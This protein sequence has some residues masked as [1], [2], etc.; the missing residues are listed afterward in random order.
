[1]RKSTLATVFAALACGCNWPGA[2]IPAESANAMLNGRTAAQYEFPSQDEPKADV[3]VMSY[4]F[5]KVKRREDGKTI[6]AVHV[7]FA[8]VANGDEPYWFDAREQHVQFPN[9]QKVAAVSAKSSAAGVPVIEVP[10]RSS[11]TVDMFFPV[12]PEVSRSSQL[13]RFDVAWRVQVDGQAVEQVTP[14]ERV[15]IDPLVA[16]ERAAIYGAYGWYGGGWGPVAP[17][18]P[19]W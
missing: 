3:R 17:G 19:R 18:Y 8:L 13:P 4:G 5:A 16:Q 6:K 14:F 12:P 15:T 1:M 7:R 2:Y 11:R 9:G 10:P